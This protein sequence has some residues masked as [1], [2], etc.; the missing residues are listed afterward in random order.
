M[1]HHHVDWNHRYAQGDTPW[2][3]GVC[4]PELPDFLDELP[5]NGPV[6]VPGCGRGWDV[7]ALAERWPQRRIL[8]MDIS[9]LAVADARAH[10]RHLP[11]VEIMLADFLETPEVLGVES[12]GLV[13][14]HTCFCAIPPAKR[15]AYAAAMASTL[16][17]GGVI[18]GVFFLALDDEGRGPP[19]NCPPDDLKS[20]FGK[21]FEVG[22][23][24]PVSRTFPTR[25]GAEFRVRMTRRN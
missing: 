23:K 14:E 18:A 22:I 25:V 2:D 10:T 19:W 3:K 7:I 15:S 1:S 9:E 17:P 11:N 21:H 6:L 8:G 12:H 4:H 16:A 24:G 5:D 20:F 13:W